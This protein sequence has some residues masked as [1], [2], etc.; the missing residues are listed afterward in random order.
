[1]SKLQDDFSK[2]PMKQQLESERPLDLKNLHF[3]RTRSGKETRSDCFSR[4]CRTDQIN[5][6]LETATTLW[7]KDN[8]RRRNHASV[9][10]FATANSSAAPRTTISILLVI[11]RLVNNF[12]KIPRN[13]PF[14]FWH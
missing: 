6:G 1:M 12:P 9:A 4:G 10:Y 7:E 11:S 13:F 3:K 5:G 14:K 8:Q 2:I